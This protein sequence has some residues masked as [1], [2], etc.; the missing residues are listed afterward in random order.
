MRSIP[1]FVSTD[2]YSGSFSYQWGQFSKTLL[3]SERHSPEKTFTRTTGFDLPDLAG[4]VVLDVGVG[5]GRHA[6]TVAKVGDIVIGIDLSFSV[7]VARENLQEFEHAHLVQADV[8]S[9]PFRDGVFDCIYS[10]GILHHTHDCR[11]AF[12]NLV[13]LLREDGQIGIWVY[14][15]AKSKTEDRANR[16]WRSMTTRMPRKLLMSLCSAATA[17]SYAKSVPLVHPVLKYLLPRIVWDAVPIV[18][19]R[20]RFSERWLDTF[21]WYSPRYQSRH[22]YPDVIHWFKEA[23]LTDINVT[24]KEVSV[25]GSRRN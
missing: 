6:G 18:S 22:T 21:D 9:L 23:G 20:K 2:L 7:D 11:A 17:V 15:Q 19:N 4:K 13:P 5:M 25:R 8:F 14:S 16:M 12:L 24:E 10:I 1:R 3:H